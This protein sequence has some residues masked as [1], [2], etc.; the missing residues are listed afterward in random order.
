MS[1]ICRKI[2]SRRA[3][4]LI[5]RKKLRSFGREAATVG[6]GEFRFCRSGGEANGEGTLALNGTKISGGEI[7]VRCVGGKRVAT[8]ATVRDVANV[9]T[10]EDG[11][12]FDAKNVACEASENIPPGVGF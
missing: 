4:L 12:K 11:G 2:F 3:T 1:K 6:R 10:V 8:D 9:A 5:N 7:G